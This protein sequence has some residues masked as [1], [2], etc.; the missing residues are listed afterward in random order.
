RITVVA[1]P[2]PSHHLE[3]LS[4]ARDVAI[5]REAILHGADAVY[6]GGPSLGA[7][8]N[9]ENSVAEIAELVRFARL[10][11]VRI[12]VTLTTFVH[13][14]EIGGTTLLLSKKYDGG[15]DVLIVHDMRI[16]VMNISTIE[17]HASSQCDI[18]CIVKA[19]FLNQAGFYQ[20]ELARKLKIKHIRSIHK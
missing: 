8:H 19:R 1:M 9:A 11:H 6:I 7:R 3:L 18:R 13:D 17:I 2:L 14:D 5:A 20:Q 16:K 15:G 12:F 10:F 4:P